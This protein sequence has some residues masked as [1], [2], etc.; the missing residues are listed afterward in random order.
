MS[1][2]NP[3]KKKRR[4]AKTAMLVY[5]EG[6]SE[7]IFLKY[8]RKVYTRDSGVA[9]TI[10]RG[11]GGTPEGVVRSAINY[12]GDFDRKIVIIDND[13]SKTE[14]E[15][16][17]EKARAHSI[18]LIE[19]TPCLEALLLSILQ[20]ID[21]KSRSSAWCKREFEKKYIAKKQRTETHR[22]EKLFPKNNLEKQRKRIIIL[23]QLISVIEGC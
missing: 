8:L 18:E 9:V 3:F 21:F 10:K 14:M 12:S 6:Q 11:K 15:N 1:R 16:A 7:E 19:N 20:D 2:T 17:R 13:K 5:G 22:Y 4:S 23:D